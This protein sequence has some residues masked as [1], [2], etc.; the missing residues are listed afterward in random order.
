MNIPEKKQPAAD[1][2]LYCEREEGLPYFGSHWLRFLADSSAGFRDKAADARIHA[3]SCYQGKAVGLVIRGQHDNAYSLLPP[4]SWPWEAMRDLYTHYAPNPRVTEEFLNSVREV[5]TLL[6]DLLFPGGNAKKGLLVIA[7]AT[8][9]MKSN[10]AN[11]LIHL[12]LEKRMLEWVNG[13]VSRKPHLVT[14]EDPIET[15]LVE[16]P[17]IKASPFSSQV[18]GGDWHGSGN[19][20]N[21]F[22]F[23]DYTPRE[24]GLDVEHLDA[25]VNDA[26]R[27]TPA[28]FYASET[29]SPTDWPTLFRL[30]ESHLV[31]TTAHSS[32]MVAAFNSLQSGLDVKTSTKRSELASVLV[33][34]V[35]LRPDK[36]SAVSP[37][38]NYNL[39]SLWRSTPYGVKAFAAEGMSSLIPAFVDSAEKAAESDFYYLGRQT[40]A[41]L[42][43]DAAK[44]PQSEQFRRLQPFPKDL[45]AIKPPKRHPQVGKGAGLE[46]RIIDAAIDLDL[47][48]E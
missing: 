27:Q 11:G 18:Y 25:A 10:M 31:V 13:A 21:S 43:I 35:H 42:L 17:R 9:S 4:A 20:Y 1:Y 44:K 22:C 41:K 40:F 39:P 28:V 47:R 8:N 24:K 36:D 46:D 23:P 48:G 32:S 3:A 14:F 15:F 30:A 7:G 5:C 16:W 37:A 45:E 19:W 33:G 12:Y 2:N 26:L 6:F 29:R 38:V 34:I